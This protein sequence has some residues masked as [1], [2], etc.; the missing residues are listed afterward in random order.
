MTRAKPWNPV[1]LFVVIGI[2][3]LCPWTT[4]AHEPSELLKILHSQEPIDFCGEPVPLERQQVR[5]RY[6][7]EM[8]LSLWDRP[9]VILWLKRSSRF[10]P[11]V[12]DM[13]RE[14]KMPLD[15]KY[16]AVA[17]SALRP[18]IGSPKGALGFWQL[19]PQTA[20][21]YGLLVNDRIDERR[22]FEAS[23]RAALEHLADLN[24]KYKSWTLAAAAYNMG[25]EGLTAEILAQESRD[26]YKLYLSLETQRFVFRILSAKVILENP[27]DFGFNLLPSDYYPPLAFDEIRLNTFEEVSLQV[28]ALAAG[29]S[30]KQI[31]DLN[32]EL[33]GHYLGEGTRTLRIPKGAAKGFIQ[34]Y[35]PLVREYRNKRK[36]HIY[37]VK[38][39]DNLSMIADRFGVPLAAL[40]IWNRIDLNRSLQ[41]GD[42]LVIHPADISSIGTQ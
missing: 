8:L 17:E 4:G 31:K 3:L 18:H 30:Y 13:L 9:Q 41:P 15:I 22:N 25:E 39:G 5:E 19:M 14:K 40:I 29:T 11:I 27:Q 2:F 23:T 26:Y 10:M 37:T 28:V 16:I 32:P 1:N 12:E 21:R 36:A 34:R 42:R 20:R 7:K 33:R 24:A 35:E 38:A 6:E